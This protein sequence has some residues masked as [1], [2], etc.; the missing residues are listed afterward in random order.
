MLSFPPR[1]IMMIW[2]THPVTCE[3]CFF[4]QFI[5]QVLFQK[6]QCKAIRLFFDD[7]LL[8]PSSTFLLIARYQLTLCIFPQ[9]RT[10]VSWHFLKFRP[11]LRATRQYLQCQAEHSRD[12]SHG[13]S[14]SPATH[15]R[16]AIPKPPHRPITIP[17]SPHFWN[18]ELLWKW[19]TPL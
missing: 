6:L 10:H 4:C 2:L 18:L 7:V 8:R 3:I 13:P 1:V 5:L 11:D 16:P 15:F 17:A 19:S 9:T 12:L 14:S